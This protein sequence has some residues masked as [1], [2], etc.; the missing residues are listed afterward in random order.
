MEKYRATCAHPRWFLWA[1][2]TLGGIRLDLFSKQSADLR[3]GKCY[4]RSAPFW[5]CLGVFPGFARF[6]FFRGFR[7]PIIDHTGTDVPYM[8]RT[9]LIRTGETWLK[10]GVASG[11]PA[12]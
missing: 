8:E 2:K 9:R 7:V 1:V 5:R 11:K 4:G 3:D 6:L 12:T 10:N